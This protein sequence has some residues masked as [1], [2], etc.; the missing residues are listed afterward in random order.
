MN[1]AKVARL[2]PL[3]LGQSS[4]TFVLL[5]VLI[6]AATLLI[7]AATGAH[8]TRMGASASRLRE[9]PRVILWAWER[10]EDLRFL[11]PRVAG[12]AFLAAELH[13]RGDEVEFRPRLQPLRVPAG[14]TLISV[15]RMES[16][17]RQPP[18]LS[19]A[20]R[21][22][23]VRAIARLA[24][25]QGTPA[26]QIDFDAVTR[27]RAFYREFLGELRQALPDSLPVSMT[28]L[29]SWCLGDGWLRGLPV[30]EA[31]PML[32]RMGPDRPQVLAH[33]ARGGDFS[34]DICRQ[35]VGISTDE[36]LPDLPRERRVYLFHPRAW[37]RETA[38]KAMAEVGQ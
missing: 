1:P 38:E 8:R 36:S 32:F 13:L 19:R 5:L 17:G 7:S 2:K 31:V 20:Q 6:S 3:S 25:R 37:D 34:A 35:S 11:D 21:G 22:E 24:R 26:V 27:E 33:L 16:D 9:L 4:P 18:T 23:A 15:V 10:P 14:A 30:D 28:A 12:V 29:A